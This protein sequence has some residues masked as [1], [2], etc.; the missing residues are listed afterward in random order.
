MPCV[1]VAGAGEAVY[2][3]GLASM[4]RLGKGLA[5]VRRR[6]AVGS[7]QGAGGIVARRATSFVVAASLLLSGCDT[8]SGLKDKVF[9]PPGPAEGQAGYVQGFLGGVAADEPRAA[10]IARDVLS[11]GGNAADAAVALGFALTAT[12]PSRAGIGG[13]GA[14][15]VFAAGRKSVN[16]GVPEAILFPPIA[17]SGAMSSARPPAVPML[18][19]GLYLLHAR[20]GHLQFESL[21]APAEQLARFGTPTSQAL[22]RDLAVVAGSLLVDPQAAAIFG[23]GG[24]PLTEGQPLVQPELAT[25]L[26]A[27][28]VTGVGD[29]YQGVLA[30]RIADGSTTIGAPISLADLR[31][32]LPRIAA[33][34]SLSVGE[35]TVSFLPP[36]AD[37]GLAAAAAFQVLLHDPSGFA[38]A[39]ARADAVVARSRAAGGDPMALLSAD[40]PAAEP[41]SLPAST[42]FITVDRDGNAV[43]CALTM[44]NL[45]GTGRVV[46]GAGFLQAASPNSVPPPLLAAAIA[47][48]APVHA[49]RAAVAGSGQRAAGVAVGVAMYNAL[50]TRQALPVLPPDPGRVNVGACSGYL[51]GGDSSCIWATDPRGAGL[52]IGSNR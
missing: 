16:A 11:R 41:S 6:Q 35:T 50:R 12:L 34:I 10:L 5:N 7:R 25:T 18:P 8:M 40:L 22:A 39:Q 15:M 28:R 31:D 42:S 44:D 47:W 13:G 52:A 37:G 38:A 4:G 33:P 32:A 2:G 20:Y 46:P 27:I 48:N 30:R 21:V 24:A 36:P 17:A 29:F 1:P 14:C 45:F 43:A 3:S 23:R 51:P 9:G 26:A 49:F 19:R